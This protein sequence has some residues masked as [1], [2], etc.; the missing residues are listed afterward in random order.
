MTR[1]LASVL[2]ALALALAAPAAALAQS[3]GDEEYA[4]PFAAESQAGTPTA[5]PSDED[6]ISNEPPANLG[7]GST[8]AS[9][10]PQAAPAA[11]TPAPKAASGDD[12]LPN[13]GSEP[14]V[15]ALL[16]AGLLF[17]GTGLRLRL[18]AD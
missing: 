10:T 2:L 5:A 6:T 15:I 8:T 1:R 7:S 12:A 18:Q 17:A 4:D 14:L 3:A 9:A 11:S 16:G 13:T